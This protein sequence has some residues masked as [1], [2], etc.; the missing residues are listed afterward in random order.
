MV[1]SSL[2]SL[3]AAMEAS[4]LFREP[5]A[6]AA[7]IAAQKYAQA[8]RQTQ[9]QIMTRPEPTE[10]L[11]LSCLLLAGAEI[12]QWRERNALAH[13]QGT[14]ELLRLRNRHTV[15]SSP[16]LTADAETEFT[17]M[18]ELDL[19]FV[20]LDVHTSSYALGLPPR[21]PAVNMK[22]LLSKSPG[23]GRQ[24]DLELEAIGI[25]HSCFR[26]A[27]LVSKYKYL[28][29]KSMPAD[30]VFNQ[31]RYVAEL[32]ACVTKLTTSIETW[33]FF[34]AGVKS[35]HSVPR[36]LLILRSQCLAGIVHLSMSSNAYECGYDAY[37]DLFQQIIVDA[38]TLLQHNS[39]SSESLGPFSISLGI[40][41]P[42]V[43]SA[44]KYRDPLWRRRAIAL[45]RRGG[46]EGPWHGKLLAAEASRAME[47]EE[48]ST[49]ASGRMVL[50]AA[51]VVESR[52]LHGM[53]MDSDEA[54]EP[55]A[56]YAKVKFSRCWD[57]DKMVCAGTWEDES[58][59]DLW[60]EIVHF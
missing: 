19:L 1:A 27:F 49:L 47:L 58:N 17:P 56:P 59:W 26:V 53:G 15:S 28:T 36:Q 45:L 5:P 25:L 8:I 48:E 39:V 3:G 20:Q 4:T 24:S 52:R 38:Q 60:D 46:R 41:P 10:A 34:S 44:D 57:V 50:V 54:R 30:L 12:V 13:V 55:N 35:P 7:A 18:D 21:L 14:M 29:A 31:A 2:A 6:P 43:L 42:L 23:I 37:G 51:D 40:L 16:T 9:E 11:L 32:F 33:E 22:F